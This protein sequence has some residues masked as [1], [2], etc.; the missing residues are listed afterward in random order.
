MTALTSET[1]LVSDRGEAEY[2]YLAGF[3]NHH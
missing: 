3:G 1:G 2:A